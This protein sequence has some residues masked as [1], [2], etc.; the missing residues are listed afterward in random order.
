MKILRY[1]LIILILGCHTSVAY[2]ASPKWETVSPFSKTDDNLE[3]E[4][5]DV[6]VK[7][8]YI[9][10]FTPKSVN[11]KLLSILGQLVTQQNLQAGVSRIKV[12]AKGIYILKAGDVTIRV[13][14]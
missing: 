11:V 5:I 13:M 7:D 9:Y 10:L 14:S 6:S 4:K 8:G 2:S 3:S 12:P 1:I